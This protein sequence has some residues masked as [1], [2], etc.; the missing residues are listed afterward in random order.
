M[1][2]ARAASTGE[3][4][5]AG[6][7]AAP[8]RTRLEAARAEAVEARLAARLRDGDDVVGELEAAVRR[9]PTRRGSG[10]C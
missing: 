10:S 2:E 3:P 5:P 7:W 9:R 1:L 4:L 8:H 6:D